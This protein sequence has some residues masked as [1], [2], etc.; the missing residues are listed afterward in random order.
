MRPVRGSRTGTDTATSPGSINW[1]SSAHPWA[2]ARTVRSS[3]SSYAPLRGGTAGKPW[4][5]GSAARR[6]C[7]RAQSMR[8]PL[9]GEQWAGGGAFGGEEV[10][11]AEAEGHRAAAGRLVDE[12]DAV[13]VADRQGHRLVQLVGE[14][15]RVG[16]EEAGETDGG[17]IGVAQLHQAGGEDRVAAVQPYV[18]HAGQR[19]RDPV[20]RGARETGGPLQPAR[21]QRSVR[22]GEPTQHGDPPHQGCDGF[23]GRGDRARGVREHGVTV[24]RSGRAAAPGAR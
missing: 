24:M 11:D 9:G 12:A 14:G 15:V 2:P 13:P 17:Q 3:K 1:S 22:L 6:A 7:H 4:P 16:V 19:R 20:D 18:A 8:L 5:S 21:T 10:A 23:G